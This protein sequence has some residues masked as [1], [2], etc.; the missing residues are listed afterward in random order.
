MKSSVG[1]VVVNAGDCIPPRLLYTKNFSWVYLV[2]LPPPTVGLGDTFEAAIR[3]HRGHD[4]SILQADN[5]EP[6][7]AM[8]RDCDVK[9][10]TYK[11]LVYGTYGAI[12]FLAQSP[13]DFSGQLL[14]A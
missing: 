6:R 4:K 3:K 5:A 2:S 13:A 7:D 8:T 10:S 11:C 9:P 12:N 1:K 14:R